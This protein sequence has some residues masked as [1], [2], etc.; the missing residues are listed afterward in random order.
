MVVARSLFGAAATFAV[1][2]ASP[3]AAAESTVPVHLDYAAPRSCPDAVA[4]TAQVKSRAPKVVLVSDPSAR[5]LKVRITSRAKGFWG[6]ISISD[7]NGESLRSVAGDDCTEIVTALAVIGAFTLDPVGVAQ[8]RTE[9]AATKDSATASAEGRA[10]KASTT[11][12][13]PPADAEK[14]SPPTLALPQPEDPISPSADDGASQSEQDHR[15]GPTST[16]VE[17]SFGAQAEVITGVAPGFVGS[18]PVFAEISVGAPNR[19]FAPAARVRFERPGSDADATAQGNAHFT[20]TEGSLDLC[21]VA[22]W[23]RAGWRLRPCVR[24]EVGV[25]EGTGLNTQVGHDETR[26]WAT[27]GAVAM[28]RWTIIGPLFVEIEASFI[29]PFVR[30]RFYLDPQSATVFRASAIGASAAGGAGLSIW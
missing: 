19:I 15:L 8:L 27:L 1:T 11:E 26:P 29:V 13:Q 14:K 23:L 4:F 10:D 6:R 24:T 3:A 7:A 17:F 16:R 25:V 21:P 2:F 9:Q 5:D 12:S 22:L 28:S 30:D 20:W 18:V